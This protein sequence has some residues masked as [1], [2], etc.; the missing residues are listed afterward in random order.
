LRGEAGRAAIDQ[1]VFTPYADTD[2][3]G[4]PRP[5]GIASDIGADEVQ[6]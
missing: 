1:G 6:P 5:A 2:L 4:Q 3:E